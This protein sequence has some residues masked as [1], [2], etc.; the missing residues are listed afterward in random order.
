MPTI[1]NRNYKALDADDPEA[2]D[3][4]G[5]IRDGVRIR[6]PM[7]MMD[8]A[9]RPAP[10]SAP[11]EIWTGLP[12]RG[13]GSLRESFYA[14]GSPKP[15]RRKSRVDYDDPDNDPD[16][17]IEELD[18]NGRLHRYTA[19]GPMGRVESSYRE[20]DRAVQDHRP[21]YRFAD[22]SASEAAYREMCR[23]VST[24]W[25]TDE[26]RA[27]HDARLTTDACPDGVDPRDWAYSEM[28]R[29]LTD[30]WRPKDSALHI[31]PVGAMPK[32]IPTVKAGDPCTVDGADGV[33]VD[34]GDGN[35]YCRPRPM[36]TTRADAVPP[37]FMTQVQAQGIRDQAYREYCE[38]LV[39]EWRS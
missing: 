20:E 2:Y 28:V 33:Y 23:D 19:R 1:T 8:S 5:F 4:N 12:L 25:M 35:L 37:R 14:D 10:K 31:L 32:H 17:V 6:I 18:A 9:R 26:Q 21:G 39:N 15:P 22:R 34:G 24:A 11:L 30:A 13:P 36:P 3:E 7:Q 29:D 27:Q 16:E 38:R